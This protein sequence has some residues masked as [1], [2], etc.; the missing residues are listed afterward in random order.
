[1]PEDVSLVTIGPRESVMM[2][3]D[4]TQISTA[5][6]PQREYGVAGV[7]ALL[8]K[9]AAP[10]GTRMA[11]RPVPPASFFEGQTVAPPPRPAK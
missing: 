8:E 1:M 10:G 4:G 2:L 6:E 5:V 9:L 3:D 11:P 7:E